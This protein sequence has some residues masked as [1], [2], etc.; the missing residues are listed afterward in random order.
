MIIK[1][2]KQELK[3]I[4]SLSAKNISGH[5]QDEM[6][7]PSYLHSNGLIRWFMYKRYEHIASMAKF[8][9]NSAV[10]EFGCGI[11]VFLPELAKRCRQVYA[12][13]LFPQ[14]SPFLVQKISLNVD[15]PT[16]V[17]AIPNQSLDVIIAA[18]VLEHM[19]GEELKHY[20]T[21]FSQKRKAE[22]KLLVSGPTENFIYKIGRIV[23]GFGGKGDYH[24]TNINLLI[25]K[26]TKLFHLQATLKLPFAIPPYLFKICE[27]KIIGVS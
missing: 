15:F 23:A 26:I 25:S 11:G 18:D 9:A 2:S 12:I 6:A 3:E 27:F 13:D 20:L 17:S 14:Y 1:L 5:D 22:A 19:E 16:D 8:S 10:L 4:T 24:H 21:I 7:I